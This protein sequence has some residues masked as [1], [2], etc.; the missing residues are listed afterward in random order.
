MTTAKEAIATAAAKGET[1]KPFG[2]ST[3]GYSNYGANLAKAEA[4]IKNGAYAYDQT[5][6][7]C[8]CGKPCRKEKFFAYLTSGEHFEH[9]V[10]GADGILGFYPLGSDC[11]A[12]LKKHVPVYICHEDSGLYENI[13][14]AS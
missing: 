14:S 6:C 5:M 9:I 3:G 4:V 13:G 8:Y 10:H 12:K 1:P 2:S 7:C 11:A